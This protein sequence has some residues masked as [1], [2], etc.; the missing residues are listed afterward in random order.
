MAIC[1]EPVDDD[2][3][4]RLLAVAVSE[5]T[6]E[7]VMPQ[8][9]GPPGWTKTRCDAFRAFYRA[10]RNGLD[11]EVGET[12]FAVSQDGRV[13]GSARWGIVDAETLEAGTWLGSSARGR[14]VGAVV[15]RLLMAKALARG[16][17]RLVAKTTADNAGALSILRKCGA[18]LQ[19]ASDGV[20]VSA[21]ILL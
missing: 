6:P 14:G 16:A 11:E 17:R 19:P 9:E 4:E 10:R 21:E 3:L 2:L 18:A 8:V 13:I 7:Q 5:A 15:L 12:L 20:N 1:L